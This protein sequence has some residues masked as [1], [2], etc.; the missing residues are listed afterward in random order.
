MQWSHS[1]SCSSTCWK[2]TNSQLRW[3]TKIWDSTQTLIWSSAT[4]SQSTSLRGIK[5]FFCWYRRRKNEDFFF[6]CVT[7]AFIEVASLLSAIWTC[8]TTDKYLFNLFLGFLRNEWPERSKEGM[9]FEG[10]LSNFCEILV[11]EVGT[12]VVCKNHL[13]KR[14][15]RRS[16]WSN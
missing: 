6:E 14:E 13:V 12:G 8:A 9:S 1:K 3:S 16:K 11:S 2:I 5:N 7:W 4:N 10:S 15:R